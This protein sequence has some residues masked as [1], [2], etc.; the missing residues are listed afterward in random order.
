MDAATSPYTLSP[1]ECT[2]LR[3]EM[4]QRHLDNLG[5]QVDRLKR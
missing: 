5:A 2:A 3:F 1:E 4:M